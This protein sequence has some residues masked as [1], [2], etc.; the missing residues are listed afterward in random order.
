MPYCYFPIDKL[1]IKYETIERPTIYTIFASADCVWCEKT[2]CFATHRIIG[3][4]PAGWFK[5]PVADH[6][7]C[8]ECAKMCS[9]RPFH[10]ELLSKIEYSEFD[11][12]NKTM[13]LVVPDVASII[14]K[15]F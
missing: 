1:V 6:D 5:Y 15:F 8:T 13:N 3:T 7:I 11:R 9:K 2:D 10:E 4:R 14:K 12:V